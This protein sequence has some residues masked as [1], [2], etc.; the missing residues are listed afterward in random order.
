[1][2]SIR[3]M[4]SSLR[5]LSA[6]HLLPILRFFHRWRVTELSSILL[7]LIDSR[8]PPLHMPNSL[9]RFITGLKPTRQIIFVLTKTSVV[10]AECAVSWKVWLENRYPGT[11]VVLSESYRERAR[12][13]RKGQGAFLPSQY[14]K[15]ASETSCFGHL[16]SRKHHEPF[17]QENLLAS[18]VSALK[19]A[20]NRLL[21]PPDDLKLK[22]EKLARWRPRVRES[23]DWDA[24]LRMRELGGEHPYEVEV[25]PDDAFD[26]DGDSDNDGGENDSLPNVAKGPL[27]IGLIGMCEVFC[28]QPTRFLSC[29][30]TPCRSAERRQVFSSKCAVR[31]GSSEGVANPWEGNSL[32]C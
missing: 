24:T 30:V 20:H 27:T 25:I 16:G 17:I 32:I 9:L 3:L 11:Q 4:I 18:L 13:E 6:M 19:N 22:P 14:I 26:L 21:L 29:K 5:K 8:C 31:A 7:V 12:E 15:S 1:M 23:I 10:G 28:L 2:G